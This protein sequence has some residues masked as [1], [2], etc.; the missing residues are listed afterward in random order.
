MFRWL[1]TF[2]LILTASTASFTQNST[3][4]TGTW[5]FDPA[6]G[7]NIGMMSQ[8]K[9]TTIIKQSHDRLTQN[10]EATMMGQN[11][12]QELRF[13]LT[14]KPMTN[15]TPMGEKSTTVS[16]WEGAKLITTWTTPGALTGSIKVS[17]ETRYLS[18]DGRTLY[19]ETTRANKP[20][21]VMVYS[22][23]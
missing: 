11:Q 20:S 5:M 18:P 8:L 16:H 13:D 12:K 23:K 4:F 9:M 15:E 10:V 19:V 21:V 14:G 22:K 6:K 17:V 1:L 7:K 3:N 2:A